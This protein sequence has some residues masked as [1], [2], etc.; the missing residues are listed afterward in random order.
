ML[1]PSAERIEDG[2]EANHLTSI[3]FEHAAAAW[4]YVKRLA[5]RSIA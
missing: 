2:F 5:D 3:L 4:Q 1:F